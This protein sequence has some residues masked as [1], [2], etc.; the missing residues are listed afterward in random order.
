M[1]SRPRC[2]TD[3]TK[4]GTTAVAQSAGARETGQ[5]GAKRRDLE[6][7]RF[8][9][10]AAV[11]ALPRRVVT[12]SRPVGGVLF[13]GPLRGSGSVTIHL[14]G[15]PGDCLLSKADEPPVPRLALLPVGF[16]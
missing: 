13:P 11:F 2:T 4:R 16:T 12:V 3:C 15:L 1:P 14:C 8:R 5:I 10:S 7:G 6:I 9:S